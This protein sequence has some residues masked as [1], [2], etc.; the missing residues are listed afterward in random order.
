MN[1]SEALTLLKKGNRIY[2]K[3]WN[4]KNLWVVIKFPTSPISQVPHIYMKTKE[5]EYVP[6]SASQ[7]DILA[8]DWEIVKKN[9]M[10]YFILD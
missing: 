9:Q 5:N 6:W 8:N 1:F 7:T 10:E 3:G 2:R 4:G